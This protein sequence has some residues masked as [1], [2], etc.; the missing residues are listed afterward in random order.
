M[1]DVFFI[2]A[3]GEFETMVGTERLSYIAVGQLRAYLVT[4]KAERADR[5]VQDSGISR[6]LIA[7]PIIIHTRKFPSFKLFPCAVHSRRI[8]SYT[9]HMLSGLDF[10]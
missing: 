7:W 1:R 5:P 10:G 9:F 3:H 2:V 8:H 6:L 4:L